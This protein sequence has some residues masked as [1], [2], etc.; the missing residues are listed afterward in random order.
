MLD[1]GTRAGPARLCIREGD[2]PQKLAAEFAAKHRLGSSVVDRPLAPTTP[3]LL[4][5][6]THPL[7]FLHIH[8]R[9]H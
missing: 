4:L 3:S 6:P 2:H 1:V 7:S 8:S 5:T 9:T